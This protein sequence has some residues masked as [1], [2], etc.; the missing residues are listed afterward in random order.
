MIDC[1]THERE[2][3]EQAEAIIGD[4]NRKFLS[5]LLMLE[6]LGGTIQD[7]IEQQESSMLPKDVESVRRVIER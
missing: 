4:M 3:E 1:D 6:R 7:V 5:S 2:L